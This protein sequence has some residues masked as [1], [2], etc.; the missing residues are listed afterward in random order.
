MDFDDTPAEAEFRARARAWIQQ[1]K[2]DPTPDFEAGIPFAAIRRWQQAKQAAGWGCLSWPKAYGGQDAPAINQL[3]FSQ[4]EQAAGMAILTG[5]LTITLGMAAATIMSCGNE[6]QKA[7]HLSPIARGEKVW[8]QLFSEPAAGSDLAGITTRSERDG[9][10]WV[11]NGQ[12]VWTSLAQYSDWAILVTR[13]D[14]DA[15][16]HKGLT[17]FLLDMKTPG[18]TVRPIRQAAGR[19][20][21]NEVFLED[22]RIP[23]CNRVGEP[24]D[25][26]RVCVATLMNERVTVA[27]SLVTNFDQALALT[28]AVQIDG[29]PAIHN[30]AVRKL[31]ADWFVWSR[32]LENYSARM[33]STLSNGGVPGPE[34]SISKLLFGSRRQTLLGEAIELLDM[35]GAQTAGVAG[36]DV[37]YD[38]LRVVGNRLEGGTDEIL[39]NIIGERVL[40]MPP[41]P[42]VDKEV[43]FNQSV[44]A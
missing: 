13:S 25:G 42:R 15:P 11:I 29:Q 18:V 6:E 28:Q 5:G 4:E 30:A 12:K 23:D 36:W 39:R 20:E 35:A 41:E 9:D 40:G 26:W 22:V 43:P 17:Y 14:P 10:D 38:F 33:Q 16:K 31:L 1:N 24:G 44:G 8:C 2:F 37:H 27:A 32:G 21:F 3:I 19:E 34:A 7:Q